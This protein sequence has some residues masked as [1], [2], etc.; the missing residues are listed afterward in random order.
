MCTLTFLWHNYV[1]HDFERLNRSKTKLLIL[2][3]IIA[4]IISFV[5]IK[6]YELDILVRLLKEKPL[7]RGLIVGVVCGLG[8][9]FISTS[10]GFSFNTSDDFKNRVVD[11]IYQVF[12][13]TIGGI[14]IAMVDISLYDPD[15]DG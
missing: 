10:L 6:L 3:A 15:S 9:F 7:L 13:Q 4:F 2:S 11:L 14:V 8:Y 5:M 12:E 1:L